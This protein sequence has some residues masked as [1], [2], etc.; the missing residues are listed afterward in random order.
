MKIK[1][2][3]I[4]PEKAYTTLLKLYS[5]AYI[6]RYLTYYIDLKLESQYDSD[7][8]KNDEILNF[9]NNDENQPNEI[10]LLKIYMLK[11]INQKG[12]DI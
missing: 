12:I 2:D 4:T 5:I 6:K 7:N 10:K 11:L 8:L 3:K 9:E 1:N